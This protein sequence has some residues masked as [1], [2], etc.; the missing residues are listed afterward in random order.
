MVLDAGVQ[1]RLATCIDLSHGAP[2]A[3]DDVTELEARC[4][5]AAVHPIMVYGL[6]AVSLLCL[7]KE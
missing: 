5:V 2:C 6:G 4:F 3:S 7:C 1:P